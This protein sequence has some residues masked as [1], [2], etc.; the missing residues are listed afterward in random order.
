VIRVRSGIQAVLD[1]TPCD[2]LLL[3]ADFF[4]RG[5]QEAFKGSL[6]L[7]NPLQSRTAS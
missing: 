5:G 4:S 2:I 6:V 3:M 1:G 7:A